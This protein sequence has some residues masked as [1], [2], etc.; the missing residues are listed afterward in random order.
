M[1]SFAYLLKAFGRRDVDCQGLALG[2][3]LCVGIHEPGGG[4]HAEGKAIG[5]DQPADQLKMAGNTGAL[6]NQTN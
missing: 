2:H 6:W 3:D 4:C 1:A 5:A